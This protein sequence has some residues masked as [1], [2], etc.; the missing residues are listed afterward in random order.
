MAK[1]NGHKNGDTVDPR[2]LSSTAFFNIYNKSAYL[3]DKS[4]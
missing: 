1:N 3:D 4:K 2:G